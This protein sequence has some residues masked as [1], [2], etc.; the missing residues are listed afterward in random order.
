MHKIILFL[1]IV[2]ISHTAFALD[3]QSDAF[4]NKGYIPDRYTCDAQDFSPSLSWSD[5]PKNAKSFVLICDDSDSSFKIW[6][7]WVVFNIPL[8]VTSLKE[9]ISKEELSELA[10]TEGTNDFGKVGYQGPCPP[11]GKPHRYSFKLYALSI[12]LVLE[13]GASKKDVIEAMQGHIVAE[14]KIVSR[15]QRPDETQEQKTE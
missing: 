5:I 15:Y 1:L 6:V 2:F 13:E 12:T 9:N 11:L 14:T 3:L 7:H 4:E 8:E 10:I